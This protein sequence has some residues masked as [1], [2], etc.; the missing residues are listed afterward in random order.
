M[1]NFKTEVI[2]ALDVESRLK[3]EQILETTGE[4]LK[5]VKIGLQTYLRDG[6]NFIKD[7]LSNFFSKYVLGITIQ[8]I[9]HA[10]FIQLDVKLGH[11]LDGVFGKLVHGHNFTVKLMSNIINVEFLMVHFCAKN[12]K[13]VKLL[14]FNLLCFKHM[15][16]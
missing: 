10:R 1:K 7:I 12:D 3:A 2:L 5:W 13:C 11:I 4:E 14:L 8:E 15:Y 16:Q 6:K 9:S